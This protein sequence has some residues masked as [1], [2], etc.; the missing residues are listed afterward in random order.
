MSRNIVVTEEER[1]RFK[2]KKGWK[3]LRVKDMQPVRD[4]VM[5][6]L[7]LS[8]KYAFYNRM[9]A[10]TIPTVLEYEKITEIFK[11]HGVEECWGE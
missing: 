3:Q 2:F 10:M 4:S 9:Y 5:I 6:A 7:G 1:A 8:T 11:Q